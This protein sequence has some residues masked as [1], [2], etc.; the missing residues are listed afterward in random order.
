MCAEEWYT[1]LLLGCSRST[2]YATYP[3]MILLFLSKT[4][5]LR[6]LLQTSWLSIYIPF[7][8]LHAI[9]TFAGKVVSVAVAVHAVL[10]ESLGVRLA[11]HQNHTPRS[12]PSS[13]MLRPRWGWE[14]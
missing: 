4:N 12:L 1:L 9:H 13:G 2:A 14:H 10:R 5:H 7:Y 8:D 11:S 3:L 6:T